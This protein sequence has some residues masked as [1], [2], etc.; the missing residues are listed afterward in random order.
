MRQTNLTF[1]ALAFLVTSALATQSRSAEGFNSS[2]AG[3][4]NLVSAAWDSTFMILFDE[5][6]TVHIG[7]SFL[8][9]KRNSGGISH[10]YFITNNHV[11]MGRCRD[12]GTC[13]SA[14][15]AKTPRLTFKGGFHSDLGKIVL[16]D[17]TVVHYSLNPD[18]ALLRVSVPKLVAGRFR[19]LKLSSSCDLETAEPLYTIGFSNVTRRT[20]P[21][22]L[23][24][25]D[26]AL[27]YKRWSHGV[28]TGYKNSDALNND[29]IQY[30]AGTS[31]DVLSGGSGGPVLN[32]N[33]EIV[34]VVKNSAST[35]NNGHRYDG[36]EEPGHLDWHSNAVK[37]EL[38]KDFISD[39]LSSSI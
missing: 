13:P 29:Q 20:F 23:P 24:I 9:G 2:R 38:L 30:W 37:C 25:Q 4:P 39:A 10:L 22:S 7:S 12:D 19:P 28:F 36:N 35:D 5:P 33:G 34:G 15:L 16:K 3:L 6:S 32:Q 26:P 1:I 11:V 14:V 27:I 8:V 21:Q 17:F 18:L 31:I